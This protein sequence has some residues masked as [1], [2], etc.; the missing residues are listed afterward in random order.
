[1]LR[2]LTL[3]SRKVRQAHKDRRVQPD[4]KVLKVHK[5]HKEH[6]VSKVLKARKEHREM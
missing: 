1:M 4:P 5:A 3:V 6:R 2:Y